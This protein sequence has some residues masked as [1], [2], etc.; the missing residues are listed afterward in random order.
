[1]GT[2]SPVPTLKFQTY[3]ASTNPPR[4][5]LSSPAFDSNY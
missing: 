5:A 2:G 3:L 1:M 4:D